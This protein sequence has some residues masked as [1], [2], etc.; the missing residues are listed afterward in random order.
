MRTVFFCLLVPPTLPPSFG[1]RSSHLASRHVTLTHTRTHIGTYP[2]TRIHRCMYTYTQLYIHRYVHM[3]THLHIHT[4]VH[5][6][7]RVHIRSFSERKLSSGNHIINTICKVL[8]QNHYTSCLLLLR[9]G[10]RTVGSTDSVQE[11][12]TPSISIHFDPHPQ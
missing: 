7:V 6:R 8:T 1:R 11:S 5:T 9:S 4:C 10:L 2:R 12:V 3:N